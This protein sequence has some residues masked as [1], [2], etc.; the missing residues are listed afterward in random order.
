MAFEADKRLKS[1][2]KV[3]MISNVAIMLVGFGGP[4]NIAEVRPFLDSVLRGVRI[5]E[6]RFKEV[7]HHYEIFEGKS[8]YNDLTERQRVALEAWLRN[9]KRPL[10][11]FTGLRHSSP[12]FKETFLQLKQKNVQKPQ[13]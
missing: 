6:E 5:P 4:G 2:F 10:P 8:P 3:N 9:Q 13:H 12:S 1:E 7:V 11:V